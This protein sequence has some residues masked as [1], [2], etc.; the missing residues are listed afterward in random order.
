MAFAKKTSAQFEVKAPNFQTLVVG[1]RGSAPLMVHRFSD[2][3]QK[4]IRDRQEAENSTEGPR[5]PK[6]YRKEF[7]NARYIA[8]AGWEGFYAGAIRNAMIRGIK[9]AEGID[10]TEGKGLLFVLAEGFDRKDGTPLVRI[11]GAKGVHDSRPVRIGQG[12]VDIRNRPRYD[13]WHAKLKISYDADLLSAQ[14]V[15][16]LLARAG[17]SIGICEGRPSSPKSAGLGFGTFDVE[18]LRKSSERDKGARK[19]AARRANGSAHTP[20]LS[21]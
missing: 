12:K 9:F 18:G 14:D 3:M 2:K 20:A 21:V 1:I 5:K 13:A 17:V 7:E 19:A 6:N 15:L 16:N 4:E 11:R 10:M 8:R